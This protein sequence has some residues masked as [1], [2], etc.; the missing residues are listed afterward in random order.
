MRGSSSS[1]SAAPWLVVIA[2]AAVLLSGSAKRSRK[3]R[4]SAGSST[5]A[6]SG[7]PAPRQQ[8]PGAADDAATRVASISQL[9]RDAAADKPKAFGL[10]QQ[11]LQ[12]SPAH[13]EANRAVGMG[14]LGEG[15]LERS[16]THLRA[17]LDEVPLDYYLA[18]YYAGSTARLVPE[19]PNSA[20]DPDHWTDAIARC[21]S[22]RRG[23]RGPQGQ[24][25]QAT[26]V[27]DRFFYTHCCEIFQAMKMPE[28]TAACFREAL[29]NRVWETEGQRPTIYDATLAARPYW[30]PGQLGRSAP[31]AELLRVN[32]EAIR[33]EALTILGGGRDQAGGSASGSVVA[34]SAGFT[35]EVQGLHAQRSWCVS[36]R[37][38]LLR[39]RESVAK[40]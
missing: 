28:E 7:P 19:V 27:T 11:V 33:D 36:H 5:R 15:K 35:V 26:T 23:F 21:G 8:Q 16:M 14:L 18:G 13:Y 31:H 3:P 6:P 4:S 32:W 30:E 25:Q 1:S 10:W 22:A 38:P 20:A 39:L 34:E 12:L 40:P 24:Q 9:A 37:L 17:A 29:D 2:W